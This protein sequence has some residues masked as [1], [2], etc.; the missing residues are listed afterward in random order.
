[1]GY[2]SY[3]DV[4]SFGI[5]LALASGKLAVEVKSKAFQRLDFSF[6]DYKRRLLTSS[7]GRYLLY[8]PVVFSLVEISSQRELAV[9][10]YLVCGGQECGCPMTKPGSALFHWIPERQ[11]R[12]ER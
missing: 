1:L 11:P 10:V 4:E 6:S 2:Y 12:F 3:I 9:S 7:L 5:G 8:L